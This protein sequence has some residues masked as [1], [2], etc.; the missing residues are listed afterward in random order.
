MSIDTNKEYFRM[1]F[2][3]NKKTPE[4]FGL[5][6]LDKNSNQ[7][8]D[9]SDNSYWVQRNLY[10]FGW[11]NENGFMRLQNLSFDELL[12]LLVESKLEANR[13]GAAY[14]I[15]KEYPEELLN[16]LVSIFD[17]SNNNISDSMKE[18]FEILGLEEVRNRCETNGKPYE[19]VNRDYE[20]WKYVS[21]KVKEILSIM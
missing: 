6:H 13:Y 21:K 20:K 11:G 1:C 9:T 10:D 2:R 3:F 18:A 17:S 5:T 12:C 15:V 14:V 7:Y 4:E 19:E 16:Y 8:I